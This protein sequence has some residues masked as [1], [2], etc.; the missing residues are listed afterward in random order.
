MPLFHDV[1]LVKI[2][3]LIL[4]AYRLE[5]QIAKTLSYFCR[6][7]YDNVWTCFADIDE[8]LKWSIFECKSI[9]LISDY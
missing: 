3:M 9:P 1:K 2:V 8:R 7:S 5:P 6:L 4:L